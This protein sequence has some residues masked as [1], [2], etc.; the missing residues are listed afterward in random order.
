[1]R[2]RFLEHPGPIAF[3][4]RG[5]AEDAHENTL[6]AFDAAISLGYQYLET[7][8]HLTADGVLVAF[9]DSVLDRV[10]DRTGSIASLSFEQVREAD[11]G[12]WYLID[13]G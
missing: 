8:V 1:M 7:D 4:H 9:H 3:A 13:G 10:T 11:A 2:R 6:Q 12:F 5:G